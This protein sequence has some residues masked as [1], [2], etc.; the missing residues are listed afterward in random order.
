M[1]RQKQTKDCIYKCPVFCIMYV[2]HILDRFIKLLLL[3]S[4]VTHSDYSRQHGAYNEFLLQWLLVAAIILIFRKIIL[5]KECVSLI[6]FR[7]QGCPVIF[8]I[9]P[10]LH[11]ILHVLRNM[12]ESKYLL[13]NYLELFYI[14]ILSLIKKCLLIKHRFSIVSF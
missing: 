11:S 9:K 5:P 14:G 12:I 3:K 8:G 6:M 2:G 13:Q 7:V 10:K 1:S 4:K